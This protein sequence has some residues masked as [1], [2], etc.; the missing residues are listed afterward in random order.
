MPVEKAFDILQS[1]VQEGKLHG[2]LVNLFI[3]SKAWEITE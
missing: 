3:E 1:M 2:E